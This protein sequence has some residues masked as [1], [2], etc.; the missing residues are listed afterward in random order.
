[1]KRRII[2]IFL[3]TIMCLTTAL[4]SFAAEPKISERANCYNFE[5]SSEGIMSCKDING[6]E[7][8]NPF[9][10]RAMLGYNNGTLSHSKNFVVVDADDAVIGT[11]G[12]T[13]QTSSSWNGDL[14]MYATVNN[15]ST[16]G[17]F[18]K[19]YNISSNEEV[20]FNDLWYVGPFSLVFLFS[21]IPQGV[22]V[23]VQVWVY[24]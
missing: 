6:N 1:M 10:A 12:I 15:S 2:A 23:N 20:Y 24:G 17:E 18:I 7:I 21:G 5:V 11:M 19:D 9:S 8:S 4:T 16:G 14:L 22:T 3:V 13:V